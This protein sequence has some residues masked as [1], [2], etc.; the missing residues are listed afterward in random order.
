MQVSA[1]TNAIAVLWQ[2][3]SRKNVIVEIIE[4]D[5]KLGT[6]Y[7]IMLVG[8]SALLSHTHSQ[9]IWKI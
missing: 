1:P 4:I 5:F 9:P 6:L 3:T 8:H 2:L 7:L